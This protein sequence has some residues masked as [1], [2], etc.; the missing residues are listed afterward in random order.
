MSS[1]P[2]LQQR[3]K[4]YGFSESKVIKGPLVGYKL[5]YS[6]GNDIRSIWYYKNVD[7]SMWYELL[8]LPG[9][10]M[11]RFVSMTASEM[12]SSAECD[13]MAQNIYL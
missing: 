13:L 8:E 3:Y 4:K 5:V 12:L 10:T 1:N 9:F 6:V 11:A 2:H 7:S